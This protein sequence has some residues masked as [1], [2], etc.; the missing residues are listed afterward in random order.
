[1]NEKQL[2]VWFFGRGASIANELSWTEPQKWKS[3]SREE[4]IQKIKDS[5]L[6]AMQKIPVGTGTY[7]K[8]LTV[9]ESFKDSNCTHLFIT[10]NWDYLLQREIDKIITNK[11]CPGWLIN[12]HVFHLNGSIEE[13][14]QKNRSPFLLPDDPPDLRKKT[15]EANQA[16]QYALIGPRLFVVVGISFMYKMDKALLSFLHLHQDNLRF[17]EGEWIILDC[18]EEALNDTCCSFRKTLPRAGIIP[19]NKKFQDWV[20]DDL[21]EFLMK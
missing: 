14:P 9:L 12:S 4:R 19:V 5:L 2:I 18:N 16:L 11:I 15:Y 13:T 3:L 8:F 17:G 7:N 6:I 21:S 20:K 10:T 1:M